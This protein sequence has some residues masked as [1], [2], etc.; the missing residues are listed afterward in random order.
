LNYAFYF[1]TVCA[2]PYRPISEVIPPV[3]PRA[4]TEAEALQNLAAGPDAT[5]ANEKLGD[6]DCDGDADF[7]DIV[8]FV[9]ALNGQAVYEAQYPDCNWLNADCDEDGDVDFDDIVPFANL[10]GAG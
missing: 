1:C 4:L 5:A 10:L 2:T 7:D 3:A 9:V 6:L 8:P